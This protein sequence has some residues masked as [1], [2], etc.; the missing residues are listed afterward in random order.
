MQAF[1][2]RYTDHAISSTLNLPRVEAQNFTVEEFGHILMEHLPNLRGVTV[3]PDGARGGQP[4]NV[5]SYQEA[6][7][8]EGFIYDEA[9]LDQ[10]CVSGV[11]GI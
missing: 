9:G 3:Y 1:V 2:Q 7:D 6:K 5:V 4:L 8:Q 10:A 11:C